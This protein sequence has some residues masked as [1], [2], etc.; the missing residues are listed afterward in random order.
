MYVTVKQKRVIEIV[1][2]KAVFIKVDN[3]TYLEF[4]NRA[5]YTEKNKTRL[6]QDAS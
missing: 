2:K 3:F 4:D 5:I 6:T 1:R